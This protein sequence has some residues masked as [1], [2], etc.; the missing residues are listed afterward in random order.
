LAIT[1]ANATLARVF[2]DSKQSKAKSAGGDSRDNFLAPLTDLRAEARA[3]K[4]EQRDA[5]RSGKRRASSEKS[6]G[7]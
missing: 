4:K 2:G 1:A 5:R 6:S 3:W 7:I